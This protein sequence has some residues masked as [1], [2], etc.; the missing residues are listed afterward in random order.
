MLGDKLLR[1]KVPLPATYPATIPVC[2]CGGW[3]AP[4]EL[5]IWM[6]VGVLGGCGHP[7]NRQQSEA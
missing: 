4:L 3:I 6:V 1:G 5:G 7:W 2:V